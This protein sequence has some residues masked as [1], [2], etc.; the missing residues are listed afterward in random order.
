M[1][2][3]I[4]IVFLFTLLV[5]CS[6]KETLFVQLDAKKTAI[7][8]S[9]DL[10]PNEDLNILDYL[11]FYNG[12]GVA[13]GDINNDNLPDVY[14][15]G[16]QKKNKLY[17]NKGNL[18]FEDISE[19][20]GVAGNS[21]WN[22]GT[23]MAD[24]N[25]DGFL[26]IYVCAV[27]GINGLDG[28]NELFINNGDGTFSERAAQ[29][30]LDLDNYSSSAV[31]FDYDLDGD[32]DMYLLNH[33][34]HTE[35]SYGKAEIRNK[36]RYE[37]GDKLFKNEQ[38][39]FID[40]SVEAGI[41]GGINSY[42]L[43][44][45]VSDFNQDGYPDIYVSND[46][47]EDDYYYLN[48]GDGTF[49]E[50][51]KKH[52]GHIS[53]FS[54]GN[55]A[56][57]INHD[58]FP[59][60]LSLD[61]LPEEE[62]PL[63]RSAGDDN[64]TLLKTRTEQYGY[65]YQFTRNMLQLNQDGEFF[66]ET[67]L[68]SGVAASDWSWGALFGDFNL[69][70]EQ[71]IFVANGI[72][73][74]PNDLDFVNF[75]SNEQIRKKITTTKLIDN[76][77]LKLMPTGA[78]NNYMFK[79]TNSLRFD[80]MVGNWISKDT[81]ISN[82]SAF[83][84]LD[85]D[86]DLDIITNNLNRVAT[87]YENTNA[88]GNYLKIK[89]KYTS[90]NKTAIGAKVFS[91]SEG[92]LQYKE[93]FTVRGFQSSSEPIIHFGYHENK[94]IDSLLIVWP[95][96]TY[97]KMTDVSLNQ[98]LIVSPNT[99]RKNFDFS[100]LHN[101]KKPLFKKVSSENLGIDYKHIENRYIDFNRQKLIPYQISDRGPAIAV[102]DING[103]QKEDIFFG[104]SRFQAATVYLQKDSL[105][106]LQ[107]TKT[108]ANDSI[109]E[110][111][112]ATIADF[113][114][115]GKNDIFV[116]S[117]GGE[118]FGKA[119]ALI[120][121]Q[122]TQNDSSFVKTILPSYFENGSIVVEN[123]YDND[124]DIDLFIGGGSVS[125]NFGKIPNSYLLKNENGSFSIDSNKEIQNIGM[126]TDAIWSDFND[127][128]D[129]DLIV[130]G[131]WMQPSFFKNT[132]GILKNVTSLISKEQ[133]KGLWQ[134]ILPFDIDK[135][136]DLD[137]LI[138]NWGLNTKLKASKEFP[139]KMYYSDFDK[140]SRTET[141]IATEKNGKYYSIFNLDELSSQMVS[142]KKK[143]P[144]YV[145]FAG[146]TIEEILDQEQLKNA[147]LLE[148]HELASGYL[149]NENGTFTFVPFKDQLQI[150]PLTSFLKF[151]FDSDG[152]DEVLTAG[153]YFG[154]T[155]YHSRFDSFPGALIKDENTIV[156]GHKLGLNFTQKAIRHLN[157][158]TINSKTYILAT[159][160]NKN[161]EVYEIE[162]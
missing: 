126:V 55:D 75:T 32:L 94:N 131:E 149:K 107:T 135:D 10:T 24:V 38:N 73:K 93:L 121:R 132:N 156:L 45:S 1:T 28:H 51:L 46:F 106:S 21:D 81:I 74:R 96:R 103:D 65:H 22:T 120:D 113:N 139:M 127:D 119:K 13:V 148:V 112:T 109:S 40:V 100:K 157:T 5:S 33:A 66:T 118:F 79:G 42:G 14:F 108:I 63:K 80:N 97:Q 130:V 152:Q 20:A 87:I 19:K 161:L 58:G 154:V 151:D 114:T 82:G 76:E 47:H 36:R 2:K 12:G 111:I 35:E 133:L 52:F 141:I 140:N 16:N 18:Q 53:R 69:D 105:F 83:T 84:D 138:G 34:V 30:G 59:D 37:S 78:I 17:L 31:F 60:I 101:K 155:P 147:E 67:A 72:Q 85:N 4:S 9:N 70:G 26:D 57:D 116:V 41:F 162:Q 158:I 43:G 146:K 91:Y 129:S 124:G 15:T 25:G 92:I 110:D 89:F 153:N 48:N 160:N 56:A 134:S 29:Y 142:L 8:F 123:D 61:M 90:R 150:A 23:V 62:V 117:G 144:N 7:E 68:I 136:G 122:Y 50:Q 159:I 77:S 143:F 128:G 11:Y 95:D 44:I 145:S 3:Y 27:V 71:D 137:Y 98:T 125:Y 39:K 49:S 99:N 54:M 64:P 88:E 102:G 104:G 6:K 86:G 115:D